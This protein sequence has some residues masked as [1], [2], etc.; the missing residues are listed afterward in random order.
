LKNWRK[1]TV[2]AIGAFLALSFLILSVCKEKTEDFETHEPTEAQLVLL[3]KVYNE[4]KSFQFVPDEILMEWKGPYKEKFDELLGIKTVWKTTL[5]TDYYQTP[6]ETLQ[7]GSGDCEDFALLFV[8]AAKSLGVSARVID[9]KIQERVEI[10]PIAHVWTEIYYK[11][12]WRPV[13]PTYLAEQ[14]NIPFGYFI[15]Y[16]EEFPIVEIV[17]KYDDKIVEGKT[18]MEQ[19]EAQRTRYEK[20]RLD[21]LIK[22]FKEKRNR[23]PTDEEF[24]EIREIAQHLAEKEWA[25]AREGEPEDPRTLIQPDNS[26]VKNWIDVIKGKVKG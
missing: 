8:S 26:E 9:G 5:D 24:K 23:A 19:F 25:I 3:E 16:P 22:V 17:C 13:D 14:I 18:P 12:K 7:K 4:F 20:E 21:F 15:D 6:A 1:I 10:K 11:G 2:V